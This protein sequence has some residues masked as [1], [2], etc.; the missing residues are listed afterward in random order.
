MQQ[1]VVLIVY[2]IQQQQINKSLIIVQT[3][4]ITMGCYVVLQK[5]QLSVHLELVINT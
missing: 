2:Q 3:S 4:K 1:L 5:E